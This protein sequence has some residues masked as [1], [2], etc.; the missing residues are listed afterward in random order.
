[1]PFVWSGSTLLSIVR[2]PR[3]EHSSKNLEIASVLGGSGFTSSSS[4]TSANYSTTASQLLA[5]TTG[6]E[7]MFII[8]D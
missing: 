6:I 7:R 4:T 5:A 2:P 1:M 8:F 3:Y